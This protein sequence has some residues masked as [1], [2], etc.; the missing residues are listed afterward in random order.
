MNGYEKLVKELLLKHGYKLDKRWAEKRC[1]PYTTKP[2]VVI[3]MADSS[4]SFEWLLLSSTLAHRDAVG[5][6]RSPYH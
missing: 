4:S 2:I 5:K 6:R 1:P 3:F